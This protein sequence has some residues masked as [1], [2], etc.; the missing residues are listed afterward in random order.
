[1]GLFLVLK[2]FAAGCTALTGVEAIS[3]GVPAFKR[4]ESNNA[5]ATLLWMIGILGFMFMGTSVL[6]HFYGS[7]PRDDVSVVSQ[8]AAQIV[9]TGPA[10]FIIQVS[11]ALI[12]V[13]AANTSFADFPRLASL[14]SK[15]R[16]LPRQFSS[17][18]DRLVFSNGIF[19]LGFLAGVL[20]VIFNAKEQAMLPLYAIG[21]FISFTLSQ[22]GMVVHWW[23]SREADWQRSAIINGFGALLTASVLIVIVLTKFLQGAWAVIL[24][25][26]FL[27]LVFRSIH[28]HY[29]S[30]AKQLSLES[31]APVGA[32][33]RHTTIVPIS[34]VHRGVI[35]ALE[36]ARSLAPDNV[37]A[38]FVDL[39][40]EQTERVR[41]KWATWGN[42]IPLVV[43]AS[44]YRSLIRPILHYVDEVDAQYDDDVL[45]IVLPEFV[46]AHWWQ[47]LLHNQT[48]LAL[49]A[50]LLLRK[51][52]VVISVPYHLE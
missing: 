43:L 7:I 31:G 41:A 18:G 48:A 37:T 29:L 17:R 23:R 27:V 51:N 1:L 8:I 5:S 40:T 32:V 14:L 26:P 2:A 13:L 12:L 15:D 30:I 34:G 28:T 21:V 6:A 42:D 33:R 25:I 35:P 16:F 50:T 36:F 10:F 19:V 39:D 46:P 11:T 45:S 24:I 9:G 44:P 20:V 49:K 52:T 38:L 4:P 47:H 22:G 3:N